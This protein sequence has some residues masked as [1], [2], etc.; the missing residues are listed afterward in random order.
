MDIGRMRSDLPPSVMR[1]RFAQS[2]GT[3]VALVGSI[4]LFGFHVSIPV[5]VFLYL[6]LVGK[7]RPWIAVLPAILFEALLIGFY[8]RLLHTNWHTPILL[9][10][11][12][13]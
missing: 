12:G 5:Y 3:L 9:P 8:D 10:F 13:S 2:T 6:W 7:V 11:L 4:W 1:R